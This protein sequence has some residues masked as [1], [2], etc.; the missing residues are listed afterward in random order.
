MLGALRAERMPCLEC[1]LRRLPVD[2]LVS[3]VERVDSGLR[4]WRQGTTCAR[5]LYSAGDILDHNGR[6]DGVPGVLA[7]GE[8]TVVLH[9]N[10]AGTVPRQ[11]L[12]DSTTDG[13][14]ADY[15]EWP[16]RRDHLRGPCLM[17]SAQPVTAS[18]SRLISTL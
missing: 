4:D 7:D 12:H 5:D 2:V 13:I 18:S 16:D 10:G 15:G 14:I 9:E 1:A 8:R 17:S 6:F 11:S 3:V